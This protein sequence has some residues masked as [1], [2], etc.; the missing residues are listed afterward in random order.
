MRK[1]NFLY[2]NISKIDLG[3]NGCTKITGCIHSIAIQPI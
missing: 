2:V 1:C 3:N